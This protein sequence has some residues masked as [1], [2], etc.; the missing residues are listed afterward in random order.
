MKKVIKKM[1]R[2]TPLNEEIKRIE[3]KLH[4]NDYQ[5]EDELMYLSNYLEGLKKAHEL[6]KLTPIDNIKL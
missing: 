3:A 4:K 5:D 2:L 1:L 6:V